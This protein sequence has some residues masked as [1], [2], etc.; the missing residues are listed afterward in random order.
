MVEPEAEP[1][2]S[3]GRVPAHVFA[4]FSMPTP[5]Q[6][7]HLQDE[8]DRAAWGSYYRTPAFREW[9]AAREADVAAHESSSAPVGASELT[10][11]TAVDA[12]A[13]AVDAD[14][15]MEDEEGTDDYMD[16]GEVLPGIA[17]A[18]QSKPTPG[19]RALGS[20]RRPPRGQRPASAPEPAAASLVITGQGKLKGEVVLKETVVL[21]KVARVKGDE[22]YAGTS[23]VAY[24]GIREKKA[25]ELDSRRAPLRMVIP[26]TSPA[27]AAAATASSAAVAAEP[28]LPTRAPSSRLRE[29]AIMIP[30]SGAGDAQ[31]LAAATLQV[32]SVSVSRSL[33][34]RSRRF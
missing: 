23:S 15:G 7:P 14:A 20:K 10:L 22:S 27:Q 30:A 3:S 33:S 13:D 25:V 9:L 24:E 16:D 1:L 17:T 5:E 4:S 18:V 11:A 32:R 6:V 26:V 12:D 2:P 34:R 8:G 31:A 21:R 19:A 28:A 29:S